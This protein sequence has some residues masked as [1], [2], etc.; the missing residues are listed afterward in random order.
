[1]KKLLLKISIIL[2]FIF[3]VGACNDKM[4]NTRQNEETYKLSTCDSFTLNAN[5]LYYA[6]GL[7]HN[8]ALDFVN[9]QAGGGYPV[10]SDSLRFNLCATYLINTDV[11][12]EV[13][14]NDRM[15]IISFLTNIDN[16]SQSLGS[17]YSTLGYNVEQVEYFNRIMATPEL[18]DNINLLSAEL[19]DI[20]SDVLSSSSLTQSQKNPILCEIAICKYSAAYWSCHNNSNYN[21][22]SSV[23]SKTSHTL[24]TGDVY[25][26]DALAGIKGSAV[27]WVF[28]WFGG[29]IGA[30]SGSFSGA[31]AGAIGGS[32]GW[33]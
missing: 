20:E 30:I 9:S 14:E 33:W 19:N 16:N 25:E 3:V 21:L 5:N 4:T 18:F 32:T 10:M 1:M 29:P 7:Y 13:D 2:S 8:N 6:S 27:G 15:G 31:I 26:K 28:G 24:K 22:R 12:D 11:N 23:L 17:L